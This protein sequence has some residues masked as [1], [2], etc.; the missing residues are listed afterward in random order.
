M[1]KA[2]FL[3]KKTKGGDFHFVLKAKN[4]EVVL[5]SECYR[6]K[7]SARKGIDAII[8]IVLLGEYVILDETK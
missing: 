6:A 8:E 7:Q 2:K 1:K 5:Q 3:I 4:G